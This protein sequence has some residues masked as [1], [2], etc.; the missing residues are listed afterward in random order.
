[1]TTAPVRAD[2][3]IAF[4]AVT[5]LFFMW[6]FITCMNDLLIPKFKADFNSTQLQANMVQFGFF[7]ALADD[8]NDDPE[9]SVGA[10]H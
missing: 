7:G 9:G 4:I 2:H 6:G 5:A 1:M 3:R 8:L 10:G